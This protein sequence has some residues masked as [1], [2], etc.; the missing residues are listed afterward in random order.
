MSNFQ[1]RTNRLSR[2]V[3]LGSALAI[4]TAI[5]AA[6][7]GTGL[8]SAKAKA[9]PI[10]T[11]ESPG[12]AIKGFD[13]VAYFT[14]G[15]PTPGSSDITV[16]HQ[17]AT[18]RFATS[19]HKALFEADPAKYTPAYGGY[20]AFGVAKGALFKIE[21]DAWSI[22]DGVLYLNYDKSVQANWLKSP[23]SFIADA[24][25]KWPGVIGQ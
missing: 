4:A 23:Q 6:G 18:W 22:R 9:E 19:E 15:K 11:L 2:R 14:L 16:Q 3:L 17:G 5:F 24:N 21:G 13:P 20:C 10:N 1:A 25:A 12:V 7:Y 8:S